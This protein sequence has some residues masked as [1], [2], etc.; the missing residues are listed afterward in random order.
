MGEYNQCNILVII[1]CIYPCVHLIDMSFQNVDSMGH[2]GIRCLLGIKGLREL[3]AGIRYAIGAVP[4]F[5]MRECA[6]V[7]AESHD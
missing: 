3:L 6:A 7:T 4:I 2:F 5:E 1:G